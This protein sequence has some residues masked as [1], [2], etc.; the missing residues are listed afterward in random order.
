MIKRNRY[1]AA[2]LSLFVLGL[3]HV[4]AGKPQRFFIAVLLVHI[5]I[6]VLGM[7]G[8][9]STYKGALTYILLITALIPFGMADSFNI[10]R[11]PT[12][13]LK[14]YNKWYC[15]IGFT[16]MMVIGLASLRIMR[17]FLGFE[18]YKV[19]AADV[20]P[21]IKMNDIIVIDTEGYSKTPPK[22]GEIVMVC[23]ETQCFA[24]G[25]YIGRVT[26]EATETSFSYR[27]GTG[28]EHI[29]VSLSKIVGKP[30]YVLLS[31]SAGNAGLP[32]H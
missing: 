26:R 1:L 5:P 27:V 4:Y 20:P 18:I 24:S 16:I 13:K 11:K 14:W 6:L 2:T 8:F 15:Y 25:P 19:R 7:L 30:T 3:G 28:P 17:P 9:L 32:I 22:V 31:K 12:E 23:P 29:D 21:G 10:C